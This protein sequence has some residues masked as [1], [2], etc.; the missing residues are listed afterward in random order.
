MKAISLIAGKQRQAVFLLVFHP[1][2]LVE[3]K[4]LFVI[5]FKG[6]MGEHVTERTGQGVGAGAREGGFPHVSWPVAGSA[7]WGRLWVLLLFRC[8]KAN[9]LGD[10]GP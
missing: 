1:C 6:L 8:G 7:Y 4:E 3:G 10:D 5:I 2:F 9:R